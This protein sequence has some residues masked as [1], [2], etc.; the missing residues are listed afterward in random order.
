MKKLYIAAAI[1]AIAAAPL[2]AGQMDQ[3]AAAPADTVEAS[4]PAAAAI[5]ADCSA[6]KFETSVELEKNGQKRLTKLK[7]CAAQGSD[8]AAW[9]RTLEDA[10]VKIAA[11]P[12]ISAESKTK[13]A[14]EFDAEI[15]KARTADTPAS[16]LSIAPVQPLP[17]PPAAAIAAAPAPSVSTSAL[18]QA[19]P[20]LTIRC[21]IPGE[22]GKSSPCTSLQRT[23]Q[24]SIQADNDLAPGSRLRFLRRGDA[25]GEIVLSGMRQG[26][27][28]RSSLPPQLCTGVAT[29]K[30][31]IQIM[32]SGQ[33][34]D[35]LGPYQL[36][37]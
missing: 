21:L 5:V 3:V 36:R 33:V 2:S 16:S 17:E 12:T 6:R 8:Q 34:F 24:L 22:A 28:I 7:L 1:A 23:T 27:L 30:V 29:S 32:R 25:R 26:Q 14:A 18:V 31:E 15:A 4:D 10:K 9:I 35:T 37:C 20:R 11:H 19:R 13:I